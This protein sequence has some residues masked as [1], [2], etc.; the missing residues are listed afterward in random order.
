MHDLHVIEVL[1]LKEYEALEL[2]LSL[3]IV[4]LFILLICSF[5]SKL[6]FCCGHSS[7]SWRC[8]STYGRSW[9]RCYLH[10]K[11]KGPRGTSGPGPHLIQ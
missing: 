4:R 1:F 10:R 7:I 5:Q 8:T 11:S 3:E 9:N 6:P 2:A